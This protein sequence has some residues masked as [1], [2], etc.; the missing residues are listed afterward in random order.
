MRLRSGSGLLTASSAAPTA[1]PRAGG[2]GARG[3]ATRTTA[4]DERESRRRS[5]LTGY[6]SC[7]AMQNGSR[8]AEG[9]PAKP[10]VYL[11]RDERGEI[12]YIGKAKSLRPRVRSY[13]QAS[14]DTRHADRAAARSAS[15]TSR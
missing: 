3:R 2:L 6:P 8:A 9:L 7:A 14:A 11:F 15:P 4:C 10:G 1:M 12:L 13:F 5:L